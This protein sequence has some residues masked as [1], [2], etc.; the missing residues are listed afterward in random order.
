MIAYLPL[1]IV[2]QYPDAVDHL[3]AEDVKPQVGLILDRSCSMGWGWLPTNCT[4]YADNYNS[5]SLDFNKSDQ[6]KSALVGCRSS[7]DG[8]LDRWAEDIN[9]SIYEFGSGTR[10][11]AEFGSD[12]AELEEGVL[13]V[14]VTGGTHMSRALRDHGRYF[15]DYFNGSNTE[16]CIPNFLVLLSDGDPNGGSAKFN[17]ECTPPTEK[18]NVGSNEPH[19]GA[20]YMWEHPDLLCDVPGEQKI[21]TYTVGFGAPGSFNP[22][23]LQKVADSGGGAYHYAS[24]VDGL[25]RAF[26]GIISSLRARSAL[27]FAPLAV[28]SGSLFPDNYAYVSSFRPEQVGP[29]VGNLKKYCVLPDIL[30]GGLFDTTDEDCLFQSPDGLELWTN[31]EARDLWSGTD[32]IASDVGGAGSVIGEVIGRAGSPPPEQPYIRNIF[33]YRNGA[34]EYVPLDPDHWSEAD[35]FTNGCHRHRLINSLH[36][37]AAETDCDSGQPIS[38]ADWPLGDPVHS[39]PVFLRYGPCNDED[40]DPIPGNCYVALPANDGMLHIF[41]ASSGRE[42]SALIPGEL[43]TPSSIPNSLMKDRFDQPGLRYTHRFYLDGQVQLVHVDDDGDFEI[44]KDESAFLLFAL[45]RGGRAYYLLDVA[46]LGAEGTLEATRNPIYP[47][48]AKTGTVFEELQD[49]VSHPWV[50]RLYAKGDAPV[51]AVLGSGHVAEL[52]FEEA[53]EAP[54]LLRPPETPGVRVE[55]ACVPAGDGASEGIQPPG[56]CNAFH[57]PGCS[58]MLGNCYDGAGLPVDLAT[59]PLTFSDGVHETRAIRLFFQSFDLDSG[60]VLSIEDNSGQVIGSFTADALNEAWSPWVY[61]DE[62]VVRLTTDGVD[63]GRTGYLISEVEIVTGVYL[64]KQD[65]GDP[66][67]SGPFPGFELGE[68]HQPEVWAVDLDRWNGSTEKIPFEAEAANAAVRLRVTRDCG[69]GGDLSP[70]T[71]CVDADDSPDLEHMVCPI[72]GEVSAYLEGD[73]ATALYWGDECGQIWKASTSDDGQ[74]WSAR[75]LVN[76][77]NG[78]KGYGPNFRKI[79]TRLDVVQSR[80]PGK[81]V[82]GIYFGT[83][84]VQRP[85]ALDLLQDEELTSGHDIVGVVWDD[86]SHHGNATQAKLEDVSKVDVIDPVKIHASGKIGWFFELGEHERMIRDPL[87]AEGVAFYRSYAPVPSTVACSTSSGVDRI[88]AVDNCT[89]E[90]AFD[91]DGNGLLAR[92]ERVKWE[93][94]TEGGADLF[95]HAPKGTGLIISHGDITVSQEAEVNV[96]RRRPGLFL[97]RELR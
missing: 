50:G 77:N 76:L 79:F 61:D 16:V 21:S 19:R 27:F 6:M 38:V 18:R 81:E 70:A 83:G 12:L 25:N 17:W 57:T 28:E 84:D 10:R 64:E 88:Y 36:G 20:A 65:P 31:T 62:V 54:R 42:T 91:A 26:E 45:G 13:R 34:E 23:Y 11:N 69:G 97:W 49:S 2:A 51:T 8:V 60:D 40:E 29:W 93:G 59:P 52:D 82:V 63:Q 89:A 41:E 53:A 56:F 87:V 75:R 78:H 3:R 46:D 44:D 66:D 30:E 15:D 86:G 7:D 67:G 58:P 1:I 48:V 39:N 96:R 32:S 35:T 37:Y 55:G 94:N 47:L 72:S 85:G 90:A 33:T 24:D 14:P 80:C 74:T 9:F 73:T 92:S 5:S 71:V 22:N 95:V 4:W 68:D 43:W